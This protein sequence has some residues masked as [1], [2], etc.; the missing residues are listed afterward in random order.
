MAP[1]EMPPIEDSTVVACHQ[2]GSLHL[3]RNERYCTDCLEQAEARVDALGDLEVVLAKCLLAG[4]D[5]IHVRHAIAMMVD[6]T[7]GQLPRGGPIRRLPDE[8]GG[9]WFVAST[10]F[11]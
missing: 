5:E 8:Q 1:I 7:D 6:D 3:P 10:V 9:E 4:L 2:C 11:E